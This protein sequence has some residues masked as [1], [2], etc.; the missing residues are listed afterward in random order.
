M[1]TLDNVSC[2]LYHLIE[3]CLWDHVCILT[4]AEVADLMV[5]LIGADLA[6][7]GWEVTTT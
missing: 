1:V 6:D 2:M 3:G 5:E 4:K 7:V